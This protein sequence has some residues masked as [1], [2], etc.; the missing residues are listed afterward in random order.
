MTGIRAVR[1]L[2]RQMGGGSAA[3][4]SPRSERVRMVVQALLVAWLVALQPL[5]S[6]SYC[7]EAQVIAGGFFSK[8]WQHAKI[9]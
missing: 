4:R 7:A 1:A 8:A 9:T 3:R 2:G 6:S 5:I